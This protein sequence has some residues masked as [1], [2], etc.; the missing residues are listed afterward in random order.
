MPK[1]IKVDNYDRENVSDVL[2]CENIND[3]YGR[4]VVEDLIARWGGDNTPNH[5]KLVPD[6][7]KLHIYE[8]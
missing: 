6:D 2:I 8:P 4:Q 1:I 5:F 7:H 3:F